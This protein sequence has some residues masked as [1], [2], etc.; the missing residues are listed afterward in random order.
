MPTQPGDRCLSKREP[1]FKL[2]PYLK[3]II[4]KNVSLNNNLKR[5]SL[6][7]AGYNLYLRVHREDTRVDL[8]TA[9]IKEV[10][11]LNKLPQADV[12]SHQRVL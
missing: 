4:I 1:L 9:P 3:K 6:L 11:T 7:D 2:R 8:K 12:I 5:C 10:S